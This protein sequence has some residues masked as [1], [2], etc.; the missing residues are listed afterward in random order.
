MRLERDVPLAP[1]TT[2]RLGGHA[3]RLAT[4]ERE[5]DLVEALAE[6]DRSGVPSFVLGAEATWSWPTKVGTAS[7]CAWRP[8]AST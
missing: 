1:L 3:A 2:L 4:V 8:V 5:S 6:A 7:S